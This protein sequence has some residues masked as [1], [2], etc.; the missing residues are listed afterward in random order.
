ML[1]IQYVGIYTGDGGRVGGGE[2][3][4]IAGATGI[5]GTSIT[6]DDGTDVGKK[7]Y[8]IIIAVVDG[9]MKTQ[10]D[11]GAYVAGTITASGN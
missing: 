1:G 5:V 4:E 11:T 9:I 3:V 7:L 10:C 8:G 6:N 2:I